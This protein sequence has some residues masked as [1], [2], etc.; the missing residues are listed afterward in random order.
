MSLAPTERLVRSP[1]YRELAALGA[2]FGAINGMACAL[3]CGGTA[4]AE[5]ERARALAICDLSALPRH[6][7]KGRAA[8]T[9]VAA[10]G[11]TV[12]E[13]NNMTAWQDDGTAAARLAD[14]EVLLLSDL[15]AEST[16]CARLAAAWSP[17]P[18]P[19]AYPVP[20]ADTNCWFLISG[21]HAAAMFAKLCGVDLRPGKFAP[22]AVAQTSIARLNGIV[23][24]ADL[25]AADGHGTPAFHFLT[26]SAAALYMW[27]CFLDA[28]AEWGGAPVGLDAVRGLAASAGGTGR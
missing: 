27:E 28:M 20:R 2:E 23:I 10:Q 13:A 8:I 21:R 7:F 17:D 16:L 15:A 11:V 26:D 6:G 5:A 14:T 4:E 18:D 25:A 12:S 22:G 1:I 3:R 24:R 9:W 19:G